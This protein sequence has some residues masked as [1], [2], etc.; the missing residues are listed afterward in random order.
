MAAPEVTV[1]IPARNEAPRIGACLAG[2]RAQEYP[3]RLDILVVDSGSDDG[4]A[5]IARGHGA[6]VIP[7]EPG[8]F[9]HGR[10]RQMAAESVAT[11]L[12]AF[13]V[14][15]AVPE[16]RRW[17]ASLVAPLEDPGVAGSHGVQV[18]PPGP[19]I[20]PHLAWRSR[21]EAARRGGRIRFAR[22]GDWDALRP[23]EKRIAAT[24]DDCTSCIRRSLLAGDFPF[25]DVPFGEDMFWAAGVLR[26]GWAIARVPEARVIHGHRGEFRYLFRRM[27]ADA[28]LCGARFGYRPVPGAAALA[29]RILYLAAEAA[30]SAGIAAPGIP[31]HRIDLRAAWTVR[32]FAA[33]TGSLLGKY[34]GGLPPPGRVP[35]WRPVLRSLARLAERERARGLLR[36]APLERVDSRQSTVDSTGGEES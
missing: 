29:A 2:V 36:P 16:G 21:R 3:G 33:G 13:T 28:T 7:V 1:I 9:S 19:G 10:T 35:R 22:P 31:I 25:P 26:A 14:A 30:W 6:R 32:T 24:F 17:L 27:L 18:V 34:L 15:D 20:D 4:T 8:G 11:E 12:V 5:A 23:R